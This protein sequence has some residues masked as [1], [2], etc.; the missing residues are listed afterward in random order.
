MNE[1][2]YY[3]IVVVT[4]LLLDWLSN[5]LNYKLYRYNKKGRNNYPIIIQ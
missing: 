5:I 1:L 2:S 4:R 3:I